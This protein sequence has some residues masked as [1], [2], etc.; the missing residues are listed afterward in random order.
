[1][2]KSEYYNGF[3]NWATWSAMVSM[4]KM[5][6]SAIA[7]RKDVTSFDKLLEH[8]LKL[9]TETDHGI[10]WLDKRIHVKTVNHALSEWSCFNQ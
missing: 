3:E 6:V 9:Q 5:P 4:Q 10:D 2:I 1:M 7:E 8:V